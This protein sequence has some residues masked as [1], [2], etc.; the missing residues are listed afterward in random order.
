MRDEKQTLSLALTIILFLSILFSCGEPPETNLAGKAAEVDSVVIKGRMV[1]NNYDSLFTVQQELASRYTKRVRLEK[2]TAEDLF[3]LASLYNKK[4]DYDM[5]A[6]AFERYLEV[7][8]E[9]EN[10]AAAR[11]FQ[12]YAN[13]NKPF[14]AEEFA[15]NRAAQYGI[16]PSFNEI[17]NI[18]SSFIDYNE[19]D[20]ARKWAQ[21]AEEMATPNM[22]S[23]VISINTEIAIFEGNPDKAKEILEQAIAENED[24]RGLTDLKPELNR[25]SLLGKP[26]P[27][28]LATDWI[29]SA[30]LTVKDLRGQVVL[31]DFWAT[32]CGP[33]RATFPHLREWYA[34]YHK[35]G[36]EII[37]LTKYYGFFDQLGVDLREISTAEELE[38]IKKFKIHHEIP[39][40][41]TIAE[42]Q[43]ANEN[44][45]NYSVQG[46]PTMFIIDKSGILQLALVGS[47]DSNA[48]RI[49]KKIQELL[50][51]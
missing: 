31:L 23:R 39:F 11:L 24:N 3:A 1:S 8:G 46:I 16:T 45:K 27:Q 34:K 30:P 33:C 7:G 42:T 22:L 40:P 9:E 48:R 32:W 26:A 15:E 20:K 10:L 6:A 29:D 49:D 44:F 37:G 5:V 4:R 43:Q 38:W 18:A 47:G 25:V 14:K 2:V 17:C 13:S 19:F 51:E 12:T 21:K 35:K 28:Y 50:T 36:L 41:Y